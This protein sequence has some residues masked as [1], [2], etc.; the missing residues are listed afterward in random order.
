MSDTIKMNNALDNYGR[1]TEPMP[2]ETPGYNFKALRNYCKENGKLLSEL[3]YK[4]IEQ[5]RSTV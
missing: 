3:S 2:K 1:L 4:E 5:F